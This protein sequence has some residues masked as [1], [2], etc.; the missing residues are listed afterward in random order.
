MIET[1]NDI[2]EELADR[3]GV[4]G[5]HTER[6]ESR[7]QYHCRVCFS[8]AMNTRIKSAVEMERTMHRGRL[9]IAQEEMARAANLRNNPDQPAD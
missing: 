3:L 4:Y 7:D 5:A 1:L 9:S 2:I 6:E 8:A